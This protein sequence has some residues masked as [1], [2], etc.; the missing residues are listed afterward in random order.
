MGRGESC[1]LGPPMRAG[2]AGNPRALPQLPSRGKTREGTGP[3]PRSTARA[4]PE[5]EL[6]NTPKEQAAWM[7]GPGGTERRGAECSC[8]SRETSPALPGSSQ[9][10]SQMA[11][12][13]HVVSRRRGRRELLILFLPRKAEASPKQLPINCTGQGPGHTPRMLLALRGG[14][15]SC[16]PGGGE[17]PRNPRARAHQPLLPPLPWPHSP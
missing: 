16:W 6:G 13:L 14:W 3:K 5:E 15:S 17:R 12:A 11:G 7:L 8:N 9:Q 1:D 4:Q 10:G 2:V